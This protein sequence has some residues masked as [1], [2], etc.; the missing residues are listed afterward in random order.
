MTDTR[1]PLTDF[2]IF[3]PDFVKDPFSTMSTIRESECP[4]A[5]SDR[6]GG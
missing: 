2:D 3:A 5:H 6:W 1:N 4:I